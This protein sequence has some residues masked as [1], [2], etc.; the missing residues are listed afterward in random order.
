MAKE[1]RN[2][3]LKEKEI[4][5]PNLTRMTLTGEELGSFPTGFEGG[6]VKLVLSE[7]QD[8]S[9]PTLRSYTIREF[10]EDSRALTLELVSHGDKGPAA[11]WASDASEG[12]SITI[13]G[14]GACQPINPDGDWFLLAG[15]MSALPAIAVNLDRLP[16]DA[17]GHVVME[18]IDEADKR[19]LDVPAGMEINWVI[20]PD[21]D[22]ENS[23]LED[24]VM[25][26]PWRD[27]QASVWVAGEFSAS[28]ALRQYFRHDR[29]IS[30]EFMYVSCYW[31][32]GTTD[33]GM[34]AAKK[35]DPEPW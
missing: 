29:Q 19:P 6:Y 16:E 27:G 22:S 35:A 32:I 4:V 10:D 3:I 18:V 20:N 33:E 2:V 7:P 14:P 15:D 21:P 30:R 9:K 1:A 24:T 28:R 8:G 5:S 13:V 17:T 23:M 12:E 26:L 25:A 11:R 34:K 31:K